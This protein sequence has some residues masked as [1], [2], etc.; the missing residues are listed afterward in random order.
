MLTY[1]PTNTQLD[2]LADDVTGKRSLDL[3][4]N[5]PEWADL[6][7]ALFECYPEDV[8]NLDKS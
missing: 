5:D 6:V 1:T 2:R 7:D 4:D 8:I 3:S